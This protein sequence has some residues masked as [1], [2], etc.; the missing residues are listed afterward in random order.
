MNTSQDVPAN[1][2]SSKTPNDPTAN[3]IGSRPGEQAQEEQSSGGADNQVVVTGT[4]IAR[5]GVTSSAPITSVTADELLSSS[6]IN[7]G[8]ALNQLPALRSTYSQANSTRFIGTSGLSEL[9]LRGLGTTRTLVL[10][11]GRR[12]VTSVPGTSIVDV[13]SIPTDLLDRVDVVTGGDS[14]IYGSDAI[15]GVVDFVLKQDFDGLKLNAQSGVTTFGDHGQQYVS[16][17]AGKNFAEGRGNF[18]LAGEYSHADALFYAQRDSFTGAY[19][20][21]T[22]FNTNVNTA[23][24]PNGN[25]GIPQTGYYAGV[26]NGSISDGGI[27]NAVCNTAALLANSARCRQGSTYVTYYGA[28]TTASVGQRYAFDANGNLQLSNPQIDFRDIT[29]GSSTNTVGGLGS[30]L[31]QTGQISPREDRVSINAL[32]HFDVSRALTLYGE[33]KYVRISVDQEGQPSFFQ[34]GVISYAP[35]GQ[36]AVSR[37]LVFCNNGFLTAQN[38]ATLQTAGYCAAGATGT[39]SI[40]LSRFNTDFGGRKELQDRETFR[41]VGG[42]RGSFWDSWKYDV[43]VDYGQYNSQLSSINNLIINNFVNSANSQLAPGNF[44]GSNYLLNSA[45]AKV[46]CSINAA[47]NVDPACYPVN[48]FGQGSPNQAALNYFNATTHRHEF[49]NQLDIN[50]YVAGDL[51]KLFTLPGGPVGFDIGGEYRRENSHSFYDPIVQQ[52][53]TFLNAIQPFYPPTLVVKEG[54]GEISIPLLKDRPFFRELTLSGAGRVS[55]YNNSAGT[56]YSYNGG[57]VWAPADLIRFRGNYSKSVRV[58]TQSDLYSP[59]SQNFATIQD[60]CD[61]S[62]IGQGPNRAANCAA[63]GIPT[64]FMNTPARSQTLSYLS[65]GN[66]ALTPETSE[67]FTAGAVITPRRYVPGLSITVDFYKITVNN[68]I[69]S[70]SAQTIVSSCYDNPGGISNVYC[71]LITRNADHTFATNGII[72]SGVNYAKQKTDGIDAD[73]AYNHTF[74]HGDKLGVSILVSW[75]GQRDNYIN[76]AIPTYASRQLYQLGDPMWRTH[77]TFNYS[78]G[79]I[80][81]QYQF[82]FIGRQVIAAG[83]GFIGAYSVQNS[84]DGRTPTDADAYPTIYYPDITYH[85]LRVAYNINKQY[86]FYAGADNVTNQLPPL[87]LLGNE[88]GNP[89]DAYGRTFY[90]GAKVKF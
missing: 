3:Q 20:G 52:G 50:G 22:Q 71:A 42:A 59:Y 78:H 84:F 54:F 79:P 27:L 67:S 77:A 5:P 61:V 4:R 18:A 10:V 53:F 34:N 81:F 70:L 32:T 30:T 68:L 65:G 31:R 6:R 23:A 12:H 25:L 26:R 86:Q 87:G 49:S 60:P 14:A 9:D 1:S 37:T 2:G 58:P 40:P 39:Q 89:Y 8:D 64:G 35:V 63:A 11:N 75:V 80:E 28:P 47:V 16:A 90:A 56:T 62:Y 44:T 74:A 17:V 15:A 51:G 69:A 38:L 43:S 24:D 72:S 46:I 83:S 21:R 36:P 41:L 45:G 55:S 88:G 57:V 82:D 85:N 73:I 76:P 19:S 13:N 7:I 48:L 29:A 33:A 66:P